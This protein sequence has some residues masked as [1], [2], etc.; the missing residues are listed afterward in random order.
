M[1]FTVTDAS[2]DVRSEGGITS[3]GDTCFLTSVHTKWRMECHVSLK[4][5]S[6]FVKSS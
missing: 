2:V 4:I 1:A 5:E 3:V 6:P